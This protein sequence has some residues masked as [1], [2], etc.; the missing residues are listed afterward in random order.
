MCWV[1]IFVSVIGDSV[2]YECCC[3]GKHDDGNFD[4]VFILIEVER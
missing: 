1:I 3:F 2:F 4:N